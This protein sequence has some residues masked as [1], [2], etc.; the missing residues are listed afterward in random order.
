MASTTSDLSGKPND[1]DVSGISFTKL[2]V[3][4]GQGCT[5]DTFGYLRPSRDVMPDPNLL[6]ANQIIEMD[7]SEDDTDQDRPRASASRVVQPLSE[8]AE[9]ETIRRRAR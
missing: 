1:S 9:A 6:L 5:V 3:W 4:I 8:R 7:T 2:A